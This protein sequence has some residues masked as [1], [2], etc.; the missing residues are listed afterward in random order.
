MKNV[1]FVFFVL[2]FVISTIFLILRRTLLMNIVIS[3]KIIYVAIGFICAIITIVFSI[4]K[5]SK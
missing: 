2:F 5:N 1:A 3:D 4:L